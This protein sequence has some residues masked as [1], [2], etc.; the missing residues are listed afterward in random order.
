M[1]PTDPLHLT[2]THKQT[3]HS[4]PVTLTLKVRPGD[5]PA[6]LAARTGISEKKIVAAAGGS[7]T[8]TPGTS[9]KMEL[10]I[11]LSPGAV[12]AVRAMEERAV[13][14]GTEL[15][16]APTT[17]DVDIIRATASRVMG[18]RP[19]YKL[20]PLRVA[21]D[22]G[23]V[24]VC[25]AVAAVLAAASRG[26]WTSMKKNARVSALT[27]RNAPLRE[28]LAK[29][30]MSEGAPPWL[31]GP[32][33][34][35]VRGPD[36]GEANVPLPPPGVVFG[37]APPA[38]CWLAWESQADA[39]AWADWLVGP[40][41]PRAGGKRGE[42]VRA[43]PETLSAEA[44]GSRR[45]LAFIPAGAVRVSPGD[46][47]A[48]VLAALAAG[49][50]ERRGGA[51]IISAEKRAALEEAAGIPSVPPLP[52]RADARPSIVADDVAVDLVGE[53]D[54]G[55]TNAPPPP[56]TP[57]AL[58]A[59]DVGPAFWYRSLPVAAV[60]VLR[61]PSGGAG[62]VTVGGESTRIGA[63]HPGGVVV[64][65]EDR[66]DAERLAWAWHASGTGVAV[67]ADV[68]KLVA[69]PPAELEAAA[70]DTGAAV[71]VFKK[72]GLRVPP[73]LKSDE[74]LA[75]LQAGVEAQLW[76]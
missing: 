68:A 32:A 35:R 8:L 12:A 62:L 20:T 54:P 57:P 34:W 6:S 56:F 9:L 30:G 28:A 58:T 23:F 14:A 61:L 21:L 42:L 3:T 65:F 59:A 2:H 33:V 67:G 19:P 16:P 31:T 51:A 26:V 69:M 11:A 29:D 1:A 25:A 7:K 45:E 22:V 36:G 63:A 48:G 38:P 10:P 71:V 17:A 72:G 41:G 55:P 37:T 5:T 50:H 47:E 24:A 76:G 64:A 75:T 73:R 44:A 52:T 46:G 15:P 40:T 43:A 60:P 53:G 74:L 49:A 18:V 70:A 66:G 4:A 13:P 39:A 27:K